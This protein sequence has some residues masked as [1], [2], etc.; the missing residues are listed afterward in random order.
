M[1]TNSNTYTVIYT[2]ILVVVVAAILAFAASALKDRQETNAKLEK[3]KTILTAANLGDENA[4]W[5]ALY[6][7]HITKSY[8]LNPQGNVIDGADAFSLDMQSEYALVKNSPEKARLPLYVCTL[9]NGQQVYIMGLYGAGLW[10]AIWGY[11]SV[12]QDFET[13]Y[14]A[15]FDH[16]SET[17]GLGAKIAENEFRSQFKGKK[18]SDAGKFSPVK[19]VKGGAGDSANG[20]DAISGATITSNAVGTMMQQWMAGYEPFITLQQKAAKADKE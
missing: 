11:I 12:E 19:V 5:A 9:D 17:P 14:G 1:N 15:V 3:M 6:Q 2:T 16:K 10:G 20:V 4:D 18:L 7:K 13:V 8:V